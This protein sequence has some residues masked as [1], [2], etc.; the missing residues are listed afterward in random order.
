[1]RI[2]R[3]HGLTL[4]SE[5]EL[6]A[7][8]LDPLEGHVTPDYELRAGERRPCAGR[9]D[10]RG[11]I[12]AELELGETSEWLLERE[13]GSWLLRYDETADFEIDRGTG[14]IVAHPAPATVGGLVP[15]LAC[16][17]VLAHLIFGDGRIILHASAVEIDGRA[18]AIVGSSGAG[19]SVTATHLCLAGA[20]LL[21]DDVLAVHVGGDG[22]AT[23][24]LVYPGTRS[25]RLH[26]VARPRFGGIDRVLEQRLT[27]DDR[28]LVRPA[29]VEEPV[30]ELAMV[31]AIEYAYG[32]ETIEAHRQTGAD[33]ALALLAN[34][35]TA[36]WCDPGRR[37]AQFSLAT[38][39]AAEIPVL[40]C[41]LPNR[42]ASEPLG[43][44][45][46][47]VVRA[48]VASST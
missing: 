27:A 46:L 39:L 3:I 10:E 34:P 24:P 7:L 16:G 18:V 6:D 4:A 5:Y 45:L 20:R 22:K 33:A 25:I 30:L 8:E 9:P 1:M 32:A 23:P 40:H 2:Y 44:E 48:E 17:G 26:P 21:T 36:A 11:D 47:E 14:R 28:L 41:A 15:I 38:R 19:K 29:T 35:R 31:V 13:D 37:R 12:I 43:P 42:P